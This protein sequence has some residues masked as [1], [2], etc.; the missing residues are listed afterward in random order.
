MFYNSIEAAPPDP[1]LGL[2]EAFRR[3]P[4]EHKVNLGV[5]VFVDDAGR[6]P[7]LESV[8]R[9]ERM[10]WETEKTKDYLPI[11]GLPTYGR[12]VARLVLGDELHAAM[13]GRVAVGQTPGGTG[14]VRIGMDLLKTYRPDA[15][16][17]MS[18]PTWGNHHGIAAAA[19]LATRDYP[20]YDS[21]RTRVDVDGMCATLEQVP[22]GDA[23]LIHVCCHNPTGA[24]LEPEAW[25]RV[26]A[27]AAKAGWLPFFDFAY[28][29]FGEGLAEDRTGLLA[30]LKRVPE[31]V[32]AFSL[33][34]NMGLYSERVGALLLVA[35]SAESAEVG[36]S[37]AKR[38]GRVLYSNPPRHGAALA[39]L[40][41]GDPELCALWEEEVKTMRERIRGLRR[42][43]VAGLTARQSAVDFC[44]IESQHGMFSFS[45]L[46]DAQVAFLREE[47]AIYMAKGGR[48]NVAGL[49]SDNMDYV[50]EAIAES[51]KLDE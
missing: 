28:L 8:R 3:D 11:A 31:A 17:W 14:A 12:E 25:E 21:V 50:C 30:V 47:K 5:G 27:I 44:F 24:D 20:Y 29:G 35:E 41:L 6:T 42:Q 15:T 10:L 4:R 1:I 51:L 7:V 43:L 46:N 37:H 45:G 19:G 32:V 40:V 13:A 36:L 18:S 33:S 39:A 22:A 49:R 16:V 38:L 26:A 2:T 34:K 48:I 23:V 9:A